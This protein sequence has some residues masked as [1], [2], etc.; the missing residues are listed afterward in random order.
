MTSPYVNPAFGG[1]AAFPIPEH[2]CGDPDLAA[3]ANF[4]YFND[5]MLYPWPGDGGTAPLP[6]HLLDS[7]E[8]GKLANFLNSLGPEPGTQDVANPPYVDPQSTTSPDAVY[9]LNF[10]W[11]FL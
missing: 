7:P 3:A 11:D 6:I 8:A 5:V 4:L 1:T 10:L 2:D 9:A